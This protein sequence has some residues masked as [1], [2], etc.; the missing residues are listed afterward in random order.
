MLMKNLLLNLLIKIG[1]TYGCTCINYVLMTS[2]YAR[3]Y[4]QLDI[5]CNNEK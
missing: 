5:S 3:I 2:K 1:K 4:L